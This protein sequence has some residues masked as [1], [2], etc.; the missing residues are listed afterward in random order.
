MTLITNA[1]AYRISAELPR[2]DTQLAS[3]KIATTAM[4]G[5]LI[6]TATACESEDTRAARAASE[7]AAES[8]RTARAA[9][10]EA[11]HQ[12][13][14]AAAANERTHQAHD[15]TQ[16]AVRAAKATLSEAANELTAAFD[17]LENTEAAGKDA[18]ATTLEAEYAKIDAERAA[19]QTK[20]DAAAAAFRA[21]TQRARLQA[22]RQ[23]GANAQ[24]AQDAILTEPAAELAAAGE[25]LIDNLAKRSEAS[26]KARAAQDAVRAD[27]RAA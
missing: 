15:A 27:T 20:Q 26:V 25:A 6:V 13:D 2:I 8:A 11:N 17:A 24:R 22:F 1:E 16:E 19:L 14:R 9:S 7:N 5:A 18:Y 3:M 4:L 10:N 12:A 23:G 21:A